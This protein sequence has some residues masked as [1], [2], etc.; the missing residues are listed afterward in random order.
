M[1]LFLTIMVVSSTTLIFGPLI[2]ANYIALHH[3]HIHIDSS[4]AD[5]F[6]RN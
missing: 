6:D 1:V 4:N 2:A 5:Y 3:N